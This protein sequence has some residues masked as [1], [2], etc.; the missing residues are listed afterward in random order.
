M[1]FK[2][3]ETENIV[4]LISW[5]NLGWNGK[6]MWALCYPWRS[7]KPSLLS[8]IN[9][10]LLEYGIYRTWSCRIYFFLFIIIMKSSPSPICFQFKIK[11][12]RKHFEAHSI[13]TFRNFLNRLSYILRGIESVHFIINLISERHDLCICRMNFANSGYQR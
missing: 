7:M 10:I 2:S 12:S 3:L 8:S 1:V 4:Y 13:P 5:D 6:K 11:L 9:K